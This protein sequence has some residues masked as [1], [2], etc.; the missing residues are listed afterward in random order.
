M[1]LASIETTEGIFTAWFTDCGLARLEFPVPQPKPPN[2]HEGKFRSPVFCRWRELTAASLRRALL[3]ELP[4]RL[5]PLDLS[6]GTEF[7]RRVWSA[8]QK[9]PFGKTSTY[10]QI[11]AAIGKPQSLRAVGNACGANPIPV[12]VP[13]HR[14]VAKC[15]LGGFSSGLS[16]KRRLL[17]REGNRAE[18]EPLI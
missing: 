15:G 11:A 14:V 4:A 2:T 1:R 7:Q 5:P 12:L 6:A 9:I 17:R 8:L 18:Q 3:G 10:S 16:W 13:C